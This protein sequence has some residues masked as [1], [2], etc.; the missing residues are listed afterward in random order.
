MNVSY[1]AVYESYAKFCNIIGQP[2]LPFENWMHARED[3]G[4]KRNETKE[5]LQ[6]SLPGSPVPDCSHT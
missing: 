1:Q 6:S 4:T 2:V 5:F 3:A